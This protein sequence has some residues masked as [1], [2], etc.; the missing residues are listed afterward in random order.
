MKKGKKTK[1]G[2]FNIRNKI[3]FC[4]ILPIICMIIVGYV[5]FNRASTGM[6]E[7]FLDSSKQTVNMAVEYLDLVAKTIEQE[8]ARYTFDTNVKSYILGMPGSTDIEKNSYYNDERMVLL[9]SQTFNRSI[10]NIHIVPK[11]K[12]N[13][14]T[15]ATA[16]KVQGIFDEY[17]KTFEEKYG[18]KKVDYPQW[19]TS[20]PLIDEALA[21]TADD[22][23]MAFQAFDT[24]KVSYVIVDVEADAMVDVLKNMD[25]GKGAYVGLVTSDN[26][27]IAMECGAEKPL[28]SGIFASQ[29]FYL[30]SSESGDAATNSTVSYNGKDYLYLYQRSESNGIALCALIPEAVVINQAQTIK[31]VTVYLVLFAA[32]ISVLI[33]TFIAGGIQRNMKRI[34]EKLDEVASGNLSISVDAK[35][36]DEF[37]SLARS[38]SNMVSNNKNLVMKLSG[39]AQDLQGSTK[40]VNEAS[41]DIMVCSEEITKAIDEISLGVDKQSEHALECVN[42]TNTLS[43]KIQ[44]ITDDVNSIQSLIKETE[45]MIENGTSLVNELAETAVESAGETAKVGQTIENLQT[46]TESISEFVNKISAISHKTNMLSLNASIEAARAGEAG[47]GFAVVAEEIR[48]LADNSAS[49]SKEIESKIFEIG[50]KTQDSVNSALN[51]ARMVDRQHE[52]VDEVIGVFKKIS[53]KM[54]QLVN[55]LEEISMAANEADMQRKETVDAVDNISAIIE[56]TA[57][58]SSLVRD[59]ASNLLSSVERLGQTADNLDENMNGLKTEISAFKVD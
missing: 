56:Q 58:S 47:R 19:I 35:G 46:E 45:N 8:A 3:Y 59:M 20:H 27:E 7:K 44:K 28:D 32:I 34:S 18:D 24:S 49:A 17:I 30:K 26:K 2:I 14:I 25:F 51:A 48:V 15:T 1:V 50:E 40:S 22:Y 16:N 37:Q 6:S 39:S 55:A 9:N 54:M 33:G 53:E 57:A 41:S 42:I 5:S 31:S 38:A 36:Q 13:I 52:A 10:S 43:D 12:A 23:F 29:Q 21:L 11:D 4:F